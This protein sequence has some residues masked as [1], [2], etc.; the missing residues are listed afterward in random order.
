MTPREKNKHPNAL[1]EIVQARGIT[2][3][4]AAHLCGIRWSHFNRI[5]N[6]RIDPKVSTAMRVAAA[7]GVSVDEIFR[8]RRATGAR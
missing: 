4:E 8:T 7:L 2:Q 3:K 6:G 5:V 1:M